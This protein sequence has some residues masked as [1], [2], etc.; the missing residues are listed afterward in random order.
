[1]KPFFAFYP[2]D[3]RLNFSG[4]EIYF[5]VSLASGEVPKFRNKEIS[6]PGQKYLT[7]FKFIP[8]WITGAPLVLLYKS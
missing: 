5:E 7:K 4:S 6:K 3:L 2:I 1:V 8:Y